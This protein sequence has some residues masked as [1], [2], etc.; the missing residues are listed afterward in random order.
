[1]LED[2]V[3]E[4]QADLEGY[5]NIEISNLIASQGGDGRHD[6]IRGRIVA[7]ESVLRTVKSLYDKHT[8][9]HEDDE[10]RA[11]VSS[12]FSSSNRRLGVRA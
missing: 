7:V 8:K 5:K 1:M 3:K 4:L 12:R 11:P 10:V 9:N 6:H 2:F